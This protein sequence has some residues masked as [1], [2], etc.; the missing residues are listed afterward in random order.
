MTGLFL[1]VLILKLITFLKMSSVRHFIGLFT[2]KCILK[3]VFPN[4]LLF[5]STE[6]ISKDKKWQIR[7]FRCLLT[8]FPIYYSQSNPLFGDVC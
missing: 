1:N 2:P 4:N 7:Q 8:S 3:I 6:D 5:I